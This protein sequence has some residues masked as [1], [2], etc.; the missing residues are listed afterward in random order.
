[1]SEYSIYKDIYDAYACS[2]FRADGY[3]CYNVKKRGRYCDLLGVK[4]NTIAIVAN[5]QTLG[6]GELVEVND[7]LA[8]RIS[9]IFI[10]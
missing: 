2:Y 8:V 9:E 10:K 3:D 5:G 7:R 1:M 6:Q 4:K